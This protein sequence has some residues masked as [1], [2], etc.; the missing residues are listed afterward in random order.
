MA[1]LTP[2]HHHSLFAN[3]R[4]PM[5]CSKLPR[6]AYLILALI[7]AIPATLSAQGTPRTTAVPRAEEERTLIATLQS[8]T[9][10][11]EEKAIACHRL[12]V[13]GTKASVP[14]LAALLADDK[15]AHM[16]RHALE[17][18][19]DPAAGTALRAA[20]GKLQ[21]VLLVGVVNTIGFRRDAAATS[22][23]ARL[24]SDKNE[25]V[26]A[27]AAGAL[28]RI[29]T[30]DAAKRLQEAL[31]GAKGAQQIAL[32]D[33][34]LTC[35]EMLVG[36]RQA[37]EAAANYDRLYDAAYPNYIRTAALGGA[38]MA[39]GA[40]GLP[41]LLKHLKG[42]DAALLAAAWRAARELPGPKVTTALAGEVAGLPAEK[43]VSMIQV[44]ADRG[45]KA[46]LPVVLDAARAGSAA[47][48]VA[49]IQ[50]LPRVDDASVAVANALLAVATGPDGAE[51][52]A[53]L[54]S[55]GQIGSPE[56]NAKVLAAMPGATPALRV[57]LIG[58]LGARRAESASGEILKLAGSPEPEV[59]RAAFRALAQVARPSDLPELIRL[60]TTL[61]D[62]A[63][64]VPADLAVYAASMKV[65]PPG[66]RAD[67][68]LKAFRAAKD[69]RAKVSLLRPLG[70]IVKGMGGCAPAFAA[71]KAVLVEGDAELRKAALRTLA[72]WPDATPAALLLEVAERE[73]ESRELALRGGIRM[74]GNVAAGRDATPLDALAWLAQANRGVR[75]KEEKLMIVSGLG[76]VRRIEALHMLQPYLKDADVKTEAEMSTIDVCT[77]L[78]NTEHDALARET[79]KKIVAGSKDPDVR[80]KAAKSSKAGQPKK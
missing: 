20:L 65:S 43:K 56:T 62:D 77:A 36:A 55:L 3:E 30:V 71:V 74:A 37:G 48:R 11:Q 34:C 18:M 72:E 31:R 61:Q 32:A 44:L 73:P 7:A 79:L 51:A 17:P 4:L 5:F 22:E 10:A 6:T 57:K 68:V 16:A 64:K 50:A 45:D 23:L 14:A 75:T 47:V 70:A 66:Q 28:G 13:I 38:I 9:A 19:T 53:A 8:P 60:S 24:L 63:V 54:V 69:A 12:A 15:L 26:S 1:H 49:A 59:S 42:Q 67:A 76:S 52:S 78:F 58:V 46:A 35:A 2:L 25:W 39:R 41:L 33:S 40:E 80:K 21:G 29:G 27:A